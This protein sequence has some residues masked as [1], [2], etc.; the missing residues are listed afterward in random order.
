[1][2]GTTLDSCQAREGVRPGHWIYKFSPQD[3]SKGNSIYIKY[4]SK[5]KFASLDLF[6]VFND[7]DDLVYRLLL[8]NLVLPILE[9]ISASL[10]FFPLSPLLFQPRLFSISS[11]LWYL[12]IEGWVK[13]IPEQF[14]YFRENSSA[15]WWYFFSNWHLKYFH[16]LHLK[17]I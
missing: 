10:S 11:P 9:Y 15:T 6:L 17:L 4:T 16:R 2:L 12:S 13:D 3:S 5:M 14:E 8:I 7:M 1:V